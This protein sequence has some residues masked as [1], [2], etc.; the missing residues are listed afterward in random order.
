TNALIELFGTPYP[1]DMGPGKT[2]RSGFVGP[3]TIHYMYV[4][5]VEL[6]F[7]GLLDPEADV[8]WRIDTQTFTANWL[9]ANG[10]SDFSFIQKARNGPVDGTESLEAW[11]TNTTLY[12]EYNLASHGFF[13]KPKTWVGRRVSP[14]KIQQAISDIAKARNAAYAAF[15]WADAAK[16]DLDWAIQSFQRKKASHQYLR[17]LQAV[18]MAIDQAEK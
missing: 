14:G 1:E 6:N 15:Y 10:I 8:T 17:T 5:N 4:D 2:Y 3:D 11:R 9:D 13:Q 7:N 12:V 18:Q 16:Y